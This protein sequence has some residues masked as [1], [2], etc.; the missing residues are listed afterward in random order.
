M[1]VYRTAS[2]S[3]S[4]VCVFLW[5]GA[6]TQ[7]ALLYN[8]HRRLEL[9]RF[10]SYMLLHADPLHLALNVAIQLVLATPLEYE[11][12]HLRT[13]LV[14]LGGGIAG[15]LGTSMMEPELYIVG[16]SAGVYALLISQLSNILLNFGTIRY[17][18]YRTVAV[19]VLALTDIAFSLH[20]HY[21][22]G[23]E[24]PRVGL[25]A[26]CSG[27][28]AGFVLGLVL[29][30]GEAAKP[31]NAAWMRAC[32]WAAAALLSAGLTAAVVCNVLLPP[33]PPRTT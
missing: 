27:A 1:T 2:D 11:Q 19:V 15:S 32:R 26:H 4:Q 28:V 23:N 9:W 30:R 3:V 24:C 6:R 31:E 5:G 25:A 10:F 17:K 8:P 16:A 14:Y 20:H 21:T 22:F 7:M 12:G 33:A 13:G 29:F 18:V